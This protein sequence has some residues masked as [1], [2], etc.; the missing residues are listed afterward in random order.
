[1][2]KVIFSFVIAINLAFAQV[3]SVD[4]AFGLSANSDEQNVEFKFDLAENIYIY[5]DSL[6]ISSN[7]KNLNEFL[8]FPKHSNKGE[9]DVFDAKFSIF[10]PI[11]LLQ[12][13][14][15]NANF[16]ITL[17]YQG[18]AKDGICYQP[19][20]NNYSLK[21]GIGSYFISQVAKTNQPANLKNELSE[22]DSIAT[23]LENSH[24][25]VSLATFFGYGVLLS[26][27]PCIFPMIP[28]LSS[29]IVAKSG[30]QQSVKKGFFLSFIYVFGM[31]LAY[32]I[33]GILASIFG[34]GLQTALQT[35]AVLLGFSVVFILLALAM[36]GLYELQL[37]VQIQNFLSK[38]SRN[39]DGFIGVFVMGFLAALIASPCVAAP[40][41]GALLYIANSGNLALGGIALFVMG[42]GMGLPLLI[43]GVS[44]G[45]ILPRPGLWMENIKKFFG[46]IMILMAIWLSGNVLGDKISMLLYG[47]TGVF[48]A[49]F[50]GA[51]DSTNQN[52]NSLQK[53]SKS[54]FL[55][56]FIHSNL[57]IVGSFLGSKSLL[58]PL[59][60]FISNQPQNSDLNFVSVAN[61]TDLK[62][63]ISESKKPVMVDF[64]ATW[65][66]S[67]AE[68]DE[69]TFADKNVQ[70]MLKNF[71]VLRVDV[72]KNTKQND[73]ILK[74]FKLIG[75]PAILFFNHAEELKNARLI[76][77]YPPDTF[78]SHIGKFGF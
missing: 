43:I 50:F 55:I 74:E 7:G 39:Q 48:M 38:K 49:V 67:C 9:Y 26:L 19:Q 54:I 29:I 52:S 4:D 16:G 45:K 72:T 69:I 62:R 37:P 11:K 17:E 66:A 68:L 47:I 77:F 6:K 70:D 3:L 12:E 24:F 23:N 76:G 21:K 27:T 28:I 73:E 60:N 58:N 36:F 22:Q 34:S 57:L 64:S 41:A 1:M 20:I 65:C 35:P 63:L 32:A 61:L 13:L 31:S 75:P 59:E 30:G 33:A 44:S 56:V 42:F 10:V 14:N 18:C 5:K 2:L 71:T 15:A 40:L 53:F 46:F 8:N 51:F 78:L 25:F